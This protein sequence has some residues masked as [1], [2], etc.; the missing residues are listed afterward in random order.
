MT[1]GRGD[2][3]EQPELDGYG[4]VISQVR[5]AVGSLTTEELVRIRALLEA[6]LAGDR[7]DPEALAEL[8][9]ALAHDA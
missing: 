9:R 3:G 5:A 8:A 7:P 2:A 1:A 4:E 6:A